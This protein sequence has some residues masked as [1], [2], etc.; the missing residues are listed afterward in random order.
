MEGYGSGW[1]EARRAHQVE[2][3]G[4]QHQLQQRQEGREAPPVGL[5]PELRERIRGR[6]SVNDADFSPGKNFFYDPV[7]FLRTF[8]AFNF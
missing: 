6:G 2:L 5:E 1:N 7:F 3:L 8:F 4:V